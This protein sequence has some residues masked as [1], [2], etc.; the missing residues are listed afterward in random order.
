MVKH[1]QFKSWL[2]MMLLLIGSGSAVWADSWVKTDLAS[3]SA[4]DI[5]VIVETTGSHALSNNGG[6]SSAPVAAGVT[7]NS[8]KT[9]ITSEVGSTI[10]WEVEKNEDYYN[11]RAIDTDNY[12][13]CINSNNGVR[14]G[15]NSNNNFNLKDDYLYNAATKRFLGVYNNQDW[16]CYT[17]INN[18]IKDQSFAFYK[19]E[20]ASSATLS[21]I[22]L[23]GSYP[24]EFHV[25]DAFSHAGMTV[26]ATYDD[27]STNDVTSFSTFS[28]YDMDN[29]GNQT[30]TVSYTEGEVTKTAEYNINVKAPATITSITLSGNYQTVFTEGDEFNHEGLT[31][32][33]NYDDDTNSDVTD[34]A[35]FSTPDMATPG[36]QDVTVTYNN[37]QTTY[38]ITVNAIPTHNVTFNVNGATSSDS[39]K[40]GAAIEFPEKPEAI[41]EKAF[42]GWTTAPINGTTDEA[43]EF[44][45][46]ATMGTADVTYYA[47]FAEETAGDLSVVTDDLN[48]DFTDVTGTSYTS[49]SG[50]EGKSGAVYAG[51]SAGSYSAIQLRSNN[52]NSGVITTT[53]GGKATKVA[54]EWSSSTA[55]GRTINIYGKNT[56]YTNATDLYNSNNQG[57]LLGTIVCGTSTE[58][59]INGDYEYIGVR[60]ASG[61]LY[62]N[63]L[64]ITWTNGTAASYSGYCTTVAADTRQEAGISFA[65][66]AI[67]KE[68]VAG[69]TGQDLNNPKNV[70]P[71]TWTSSNEDVAT[72]KDGTVSV[73]AVGETTITAAFA[74]NDDYKNASVSYTLTIQDSRVAI[75]PAFAEEEVT[76]NVTETVAAPALSGNTGNA[77]VTYESDNTAV[78]TVD[79]NGQV[80][81][82]A[83]GTATITATIAATNEYQGGT[84]TFTVTVVDPN[85]PGTQGRPY[86][87]AEAIAAIDAGTGVT[88]VYATGIVSEIVTAY[89]S[90]YGNIS[91]NISA[92]GTTDGDQLQAYR[93]KSYNGE[94]FTSEDDIQEGDVVV[95]YGNLVKYNSTYEFGANNQLVSLERVVPTYTLDVK[96]GDHG[97]VA[98][99]VDGEAWDGQTEIAQGATVELTATPAE[100][101]AF[102]SWTVVGVELEDATVNPVSFTMA[103][104]VMIEATYAD[105]TTSYEVVVEDDVEG[106]VITS[107]KESA[108]AGEK[109]VISYELTK[110]YAFSEWVVEDIDSNPVTVSYENEEYSFTMPAN[111]V[112]ISATFKKI[113]TVLYSVAGVDGEVERKDGDA[114]N[115]NV[116]EAVNGMAF[117]G[118]STTDDLNA[119][120]FVANDAAVTDD[121]ILFAMFTAKSGSTYQLVEADQENWTGDYLIAYDNTTFAN[122]KIGGTDGLGKVST[123][124][125]PETA[126]SGNTVDAEWG[127]KYNVTFV[128]VDAADLSKG[129]LMMTKDGKYNYQ[130]S[131]SNGLSASANLTTAVNYPLSITFKSSDD[132]EISIAAGAIF[133]YN[134][135]GYFRFYKDGSQQAIH[136]YKKVTGES[137][138][139]LAVPVEASISAAKYATFHSDKNVYF[140]TS[141]VEVYTAHYNGSYVELSEVAD[142]L[143]PAKT[144]VVLHK[145]VDVQTTVEAYEVGDVEALTNNGLKISDGA[146]AVGNG[147]YVLSNKSHGVGFY[148]W[149]SDQS[150][151]AGKVYIEIPAAG[152]AREF[153][154]MVAGGSTTGISEVTSHAA[155]Q[156]GVIYDLQGRKV[157]TLKRG[158]YIINGKKA[159]IK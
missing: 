94:N 153:I 103:G 2:L 38:Q 109:V 145:D 155:Q 119:P 64:S 144:A 54:V 78:A 33:A 55:E 111:D 72:V 17:S 92:D 137:V 53:S 29:A 79:E 123:H 135:N 27:E 30:V 138:Y 93:G 147:I 88:G 73:K 149:A 35:E 81:G 84:A 75:E 47:V 100:G 115:L 113:H 18:N 26:T 122:G 4:G 39:Y 95:I 66:D 97:T 86:T 67:T 5:I 44:V 31:V 46:S 23:S 65:E 1:L 77:T 76:V 49:W 98:V 83:D 19:K 6:T 99:T 101:W 148:Q 58:L 69:Y 22:T 143:V 10:Q 12:L 37:L 9:E 117:A 11:F 3:L 118:W 156:S 106:G 132:I 32:T 152:E 36:V 68:I 24:V 130:T 151:S 45:T 142:G 127:D 50:K 48:Q 57:E 126:L 108:K 8:D 91:Y 90:Q 129:Y 34:E 128:A 102:T 15:T 74:G 40:E 112:I 104:E 120:E 71:I 60:S 139:T 157:E 150:L 41:S 16:R 80:T 62:L 20:A 87:V 124:V 114:L 85:K 121:M 133:H 14:V 43:P 52:S 105:A 140:S 25:G 42:V 63:T 125:D 131:N 116:P 146:T 28:G 70:A 134:T 158:L 51:Q 159:I 89:S 110:G 7:L 82:V 154:G 21:S 107:D 61:A 96:A 141:D 59:T 136:L 13:Y 56:A